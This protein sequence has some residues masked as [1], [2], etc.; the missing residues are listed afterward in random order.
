M[1]FC[2]KCKGMPIHLQTSRTL[3]LLFVVLSLFCPYRPISWSTLRCLRT[4]LSSVSGNSLLAWIALFRSIK[5][6]L[7]V[8]LLFW[9]LL[10]LCCWKHVDWLSPVASFCIEK[11][12]LLT[13]SRNECYPC[14]SS[15][16][17]FRRV[18]CRVLNF[19]WRSLSKLRSP[20]LFCG[21][22]YGA[23]PFLDAPM[24]FSIAWAVIKPWLEERTRN[25]I[26]I[27]RGPG[28]DKLLQVWSGVWLIWFLYF[29]YI[30]T[31]YLMD[32]YLIYLFCFDWWV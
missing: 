29:G 2:G 25:K 20:L 30:V 8:C 27:I 16:G 5:T 10:L 23:F 7:Y 15:F 19:G 32:W 6:S 11:H 17:N 21:S 12:S 4:C 24:I 3:P 28:T 18:S 26:H 13:C 22:I 14:L 1:S 9:Q 31:I